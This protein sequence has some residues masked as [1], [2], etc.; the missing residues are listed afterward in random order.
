MIKYKIICECEDSYDVDAI[1]NA[2]KNKLLLEGLYDSVFRP[3]LKH[4]T[5]KKEIEAYTLVWEKLSEYLNEG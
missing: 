2:L 5:K 4:G 3:V 1:T